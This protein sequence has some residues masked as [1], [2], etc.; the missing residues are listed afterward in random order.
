MTVGRAHIAT[1]GLILVAACTSERAGSGREFEDKPPTPHALQ[2]VNASFAG[3]PLTDIGRRPLFEW[4]YVD[5]ESGGPIRYQLEVDDDCKPGDL[6]ACA[7]SSPE[8]RETALRE[9]DY[10][11]PMPLPMNA[12]PPLGRRYYWRVRACGKGCSPWSRVRYVE[13]GRVE[14]DLNGDGYSDVVI[15]APL[16]DNGGLDRGSAFVYYGGPAGVDTSR[17]TRLD[18]PEK[19]D[20]NAFG[21][22]ASIAG[23]VDGDGYADLIVGAAGAKEERGLA[24]LYHGG[25]DGVDVAFR[26]ELGDRSGVPE[27]WFGASVAGAGDVDG[28]GYADVLVGASGHDGEGYD[29]GMAFFYRGGADGVDPRNPLRITSLEPRDYDSF[30]FALAPAG[31]VNGDGYMD[32]V[33]G[34]PGIDLAGEL[35]GVDRGAVYVF[36]GGPY[37]PSLIP[38]VK[39]EAP[40]PLD[41][42]RFGFG[43]STAGDVNADGYA[44]I[45][46]GAPGSDGSII[47]DGAVYVFHGGV[48][49]IDGIPATVLEDPRVEEYDRFGTSCAGAGDVNGDGFDDL[50]VGTSGTE[51]GRG[52]IFHGS[53]EGVS[54]LPGA[55]LH[56]PLGPGYNH[57]ADAVAGAG[58]VNGDGFDDILIGASGSDNGG[59]YR[60]SAVVYPGTHAGVDPARAVRVDNPDTGEH[61]HFG[62]VVAGR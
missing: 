9:A 8:I 19:Q 2:P 52:V 3:S 30:G 15:S 53:R 33:I 42:D 23:D 50:V 43:V 4:S 14:G 26:T 46:V 5:A 7:F 49:G 41:H 10:R 20:G 21:V 61:D 38:G 55:V 60:G 39:L 56:D 37:G 31:D 29:W 17:G 34:S 22:A 12:K 13:V 32:V 54:P 27:D 47:D 57:F 58:D 16:V 48:A 28:D 36:H 35:R 11:P 59:V 40:V 1:A 24:Y 51:R 44:D 45:V 18:A 62:H 25:P 6:Q